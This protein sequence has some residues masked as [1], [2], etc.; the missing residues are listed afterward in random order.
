MYTYNPIQ[1]QARASCEPRVSVA[2]TSGSYEASYNELAMNVLATDLKVV[3]M[4]D[5]EYTQ[6]QQILFSTMDSQQPEG[7]VEAKLS[8]SFYSIGSHPLCH[9]DM[10][11]GHDAFAGPG[12]HG[13][14]L[15]SNALASG[16]VPSRLDFRES[17]MPS[18]SSQLSHV[19]TPRNS[20]KHHKRRDGSG[21]HNAGTSKGMDDAVPAGGKA[22]FKSSIR[23][24]L[25]D[26]FNNMKA[27]AP[28]YQETQNSRITMS[29]LASA[30][31]NPAQLTGVQQQIKGTELG[32]NKTYG[33]SVL[34][35]PYPA[36]A[37]A[38]TGNGAKCQTQTTFSGSFRNSCSAA[39]VT[40]Q[41]EMSLQGRYSIRY[42]HES[43]SSNM[44]NKS[45]LDQGWIKAGEANGK[46]TINKRSRGRAQP[47]G[48]NTERKV[49]GEI[50]N[51]PD[52][53]NSVISWLSVQ[54]TP[55]EEPAGSLPPAGPTQRREKHN[56]MERDRRRRIRVCCDELNTLVP[57]CRGDTDKAT[58]LQWTT[59]YLKYLQETHGES[60]KKVNV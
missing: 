36:Y 44:G 42:P 58:T 33:P 60:L 6:L 23:V 25:E 9:H 5:V 29:N 4:A 12:G 47:P 52:G 48:P 34:Q 3:D 2:P 57:F 21:D 32:K 38:S 27:E 53:Q 41:Q 50:Q 1:D 45:F 24:R 13:A 11:K 35:Y 22:G 18:E 51:A 28:R 15:E 46:Q 43:T 26:R 55:G 14:Y 59:A 8:S 54:S 31:C 17:T 7:D 10:I 49:L 16:H 56:R 40:K 19:K 39:E 30:F 37:S 20:S